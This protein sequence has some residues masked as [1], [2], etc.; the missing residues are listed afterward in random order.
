M[1]AFLNWTVAPS[2]CI[3]VYL[4]PCILTWLH[5]AS[6]SRIPNW[7][8]WGYRDIVQW[9]STKIH[10]LSRKICLPIATDAWSCIR[11]KAGTLLSGPANKWTRPKQRQILL[12]WAG[13]RINRG[14][15]PFW[16]MG[17]NELLQYLVAK[18][19]R[20]F[21]TAW[22]RHILNISITEVLRALHKHVISEIHFL[23]TVPW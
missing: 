9:S 23:L 8:Q 7:F 18:N 13:R 15:F 12:A 17:R 14:T 22:S 1:C 5:S 6:H 21:C 19:F 11:T 20:K 10:M 4:S 3:S 16:I 2:R